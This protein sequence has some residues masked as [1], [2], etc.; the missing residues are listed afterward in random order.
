MNIFQDYFRRHLF[1]FHSVAPSLSVVFWPHSGV[2]QSQICQA[3]LSWVFDDV[4]A[5][6]S[7]P[8]KYDTLRLLSTN[9]NLKGPN[10]AAAERRRRCVSTTTVR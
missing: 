4:R 6:Q 5:P 9:S 8:I 2:R 7:S 3:E 10:P 1:S